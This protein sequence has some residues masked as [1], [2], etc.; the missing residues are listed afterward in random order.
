MFGKRSDGRRIILDD[1]ITGLVPYLMPKRDDAQVMITLNIDCDTLTRYIRAQRD[2]GHQI[3]YMELIIA[4]YVR[5]M[6]RYPE[7]NRF[8]MNRKVYARN[9]MAISL[10]VLKN[11]DDENIRETTIKIKFAPEATIYDVHERFSAAIEE[12]RK[13]TASNLTDKVAKV[14]LGAHWLT[15]SIVS[16]ARVLDRYNMMPRII[17]EAS[18]FHTSM[19]ISNMASLGMPSI[20]HHIYNF[21]TTSIFFGMGR[22][23]RV[24]EPARDGGVH[25]RRVIPLGVVIDERIC[26][27]AEYGRAF[28]YLRELLAH[29]EMLETAPEDVKLETPQIPL[30]C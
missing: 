26:C 18:P 2:K 9:H 4:A 22:V 24:P 15:A 17:T 21:G 10:A 20:Y 6:S 1:P 30:S 25:F 5:T 11:R 3:S 27:G 28:T 16:L 29:P 12:N 19:F 7:L 8:I 23:E 14:V 13:V